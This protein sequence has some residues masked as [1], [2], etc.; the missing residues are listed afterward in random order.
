MNRD[1]LFFTVKL[2][3]VRWWCFWL[4]RCSLCHEVFESV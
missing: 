2:L 4:W 3:I 1:N